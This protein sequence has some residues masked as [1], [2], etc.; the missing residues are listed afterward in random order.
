MG[1][2]VFISGSNRGIGKAMVHAFT[3]A[4]YNVVAH[5]RKRD[6]ALEKE[7][8]SIAKEKGVTI[9]T[10]HFDMLD[11]DAMKNSIKQLRKE[12][13]EIDILVNNAGIAHGGLFQMTSV[14]TIRNVFDVNFFSHLELTQ[15][16]LR[17]MVKKGK[18]CIINIASISGLD[19][20]AGNCAYG[21]S[22]AALIAWTKTLASELG[23][24]G[25]RVNAIAP[26]LTDTGMATQM[27][28]QAGI[29]MLRES[30]LQRL[31]K[32]EEIANIAV[33][34]ASEEASFINGEV[35]RADGGKS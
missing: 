19:S 33:F 29:S 26:G 11:L 5:S 30:A 32:P 35:I 8:A 21:A 20:K 27:E 31:A 1:G 4:G 9:Y 34:L 23:A 17:P 22:K 2:T 7:Y 18:G 12:K 6:E 10:L 24:R 14:D 13:I 25:I 15:A 28:D 3:K 16:L